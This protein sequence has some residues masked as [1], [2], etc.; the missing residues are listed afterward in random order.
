MPAAVMPGR[1]CVTHGD[2]LTKA[3]DSSRTLS[4]SSTHGF[5]ILCDEDGIIQKFLGDDSELVLLAKPGSALTALFDRRS[6]QKVLD[7]LRVLREQRSTFGWELDVALEPESRTMYFGGG[8]IDTGM[9]VIGIN[10]TKGFDRFYDELTKINNEQANTLRNLVKEQF[11]DTRNKQEKTYTD[12]SRVNNDLVNVQR[13]LAKK[14]TELARLNEQKSQLLGIAAHDLR[15]PLTVILGYTKFLLQRA[16]PDMKQDHAQFL[17]QILYSSEFMLAMLEDLLDVSQIEAGK[18]QLK[19]ESV[20][21]VELVRHCVSLNTVIAEQKRITIGFEAN[22]KFPLVS[23]DSHK[24]QQ[25]INN[26]ISNAIKYSHPDTHIQVS[27]SAQNNELKCKIED[28]G[29]GIPADEIEHLFKPFSRT[30]V[31]TTA[32][33]KSAGL[34]LAIAK[35][36]IQGHGGDIRVESQVGKGS[37]FGF[38]LPLS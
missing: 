10:S 3:F 13:E 7:F 15:N 12:L 36:I 6:F 8:I 5:A 30:S 27:L 9:I 25:V 11:Q 35:K 29:Q 37:C 24:V 1:P 34:G 33:E 14:N 2:Y 20:D 18:L 31:R 19:I 26:L 28:Q 23:I 17:E 22:G 38:T 21:L 4:S 32:G 16:A